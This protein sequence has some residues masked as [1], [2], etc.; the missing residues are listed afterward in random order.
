MKAIDQG[1]VSITL[2]DRIKQYEAD[3]QSVKNDIS[4]EKIKSNPIQVT[5]EHIIFFLEK[6]ALLEGE[7]FKDRIIPQW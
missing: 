3:L 4:L 1:L 2:M 5:K 6:F 7:E